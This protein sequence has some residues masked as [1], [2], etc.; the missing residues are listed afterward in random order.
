MTIHLCRNLSSL[1]SSL[2]PA[3]GM[4]FLS[5]FMHHVADYVATSNV[6]FDITSSSFTKAAFNQNF[7]FRSF[8]TISGVDNSVAIPSDTYTVTVSDVNRIL[9]LKSDAYPRHN[10]G[11][12]R[13]LSVNTGSNSVSVDYQSTELPPADTV[14]WR[15]YASEH[16]VT[17]SWI[18]GS[19][20]SSGYTSRNNSTCS[21]IMFKKQ[22]YQSVRLCLEDRSA[23]QTNIPAGFSITLGASEHN[24]IPV[25]FEEDFG[26]LNGPMFFNTT[27]SLYRG[28]AVGLGTGIL[29]TQWM[30]GKFTFTALADDVTGTTLAICQNENFVTGGNSLVCFGYANDNPNSSFSMLPLEKKDIIKNLFIIG[31]S[32]PTQ[33][34]TIRSGF[35][36]DSHL[37]GLAWNDFNMLSPCILSQYANSKNITP[38]HRTITTANV[39]PFNNRTELSD[40]E[41]LVGTLRSNLSFT[42]SSIF[43]FAP[44]RL[45]ILPFINIGRSNYTSWALTPDKSKYHLSGGI[46]ID[47]SGP[48][49]STSLTGSNNVVLSL[50]SSF[51]DKSG[52]EIL[53]TEPYMYDPDYSVDIVEIEE[54]KDIDATRYKKTYSYYRQQGIDLELTKIGSKK[55]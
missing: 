6:N 15:I 37:Q 44:K 7:P 40:V 10:S 2:S 8:A 26:Y 55:Q 29:G 27:S 50:T 3:T 38:N 11:L 30:F 35:S 52:L 19:N 28:T 45:G 43:N 53:Q 39:C 17:S 48:H 24:T 47:W 14:S 46:F 49:L 34:L 5:M 41:I 54:N 32:S 4:Y 21:R 36:I 18:T 25:D 51:F 31:G 22:D 33:A 12:F 1:S 16:E 42:T 23:V 20:G 9:A 13:V